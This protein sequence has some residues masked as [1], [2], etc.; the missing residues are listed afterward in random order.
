MSKIQKALKRIQSNPRKLEDTSPHKI[1]S[2][3]Q[4]L[5]NADELGDFEQPEA[6]VEFNQGALRDAGLIAPDYH[7]RALAD[8]YREIKRPL[9]AN[10]YGRRVTQIEQGNLIMVTSAVPGEGK[11]FTSI[12]LALSI[13]QEQDHTVLLVDADVAKP[14]ISNIFGLTEM[15]GLLDLVED[16]DRVPESLV[17]T[18]DIDGLS[19][20]PA[21]QPRENATELLS[22]S[23]MDHV[24]TALANRYPGR[25][26]LFDTPPLL[27][28]SEANAITD[29][30]GQVVLVVKA[31]DT[32][33]GAV[34]SALHQLHNDQAV[35][36][37]LNQSRVE[38]SKGNYGYGHNYGY[39][40]G[41][42]NTNTP[43]RP[44][45]TESLWGQK[46]E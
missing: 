36:L 14:H 13:A 37:V 29:L 34:M 27:E 38:S 35:N 22:S 40:Y 15:S 1:A 44:E 30:A 39:G 20:L 26:V 32:S 45:K 31:E 3:T 43:E 42:Q 6:R 7:E 9:I 2:V 33:H 46:D 11:T 19:I 25:L 4:R 8:Q 41:Q 28:T 23:R 21:G 17:L 24:V 16:K 18:T 10:A 12:N 5:E